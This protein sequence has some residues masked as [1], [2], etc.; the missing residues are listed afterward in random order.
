MAEHAVAEVEGPQTKKPRSLLKLLL[1]G[2]NVLLFLA[3]V[4]SLAWTKFGPKPQVT[5]TVAQEQDHLEEQKDDAAYKPVAKGHEAP[6]KASE[7]H[8]NSAP[9]KAQG[10]HG[11]EAGKGHGSSA[12]AKPSGG[13]GGEAGKG[14]GGGSSNPALVS[15]APF[16]VNLSGDQGQRYLRLVAQVEVRGDLAKD[17]LEKHLPEVRNRLLFLLTSK[18]FADISSIQGKY[19]LQADITKNINEMLDGSFIRKTYFTE[20][21]V[22]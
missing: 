11:G 16:L 7:G 14:S 9:S 2:L 22:Q 12:A 6:A 19:D 15:L 4:G 10:G 13:H 21:I 3:G 5:A 20:F 18:T 1:L 8:G 17:E